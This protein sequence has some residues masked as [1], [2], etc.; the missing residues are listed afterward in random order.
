MP[1]DD[2][3]RAEESDRAADGH[4]GVSA[5]GRDCRQRGVRLGQCPAAK[6]M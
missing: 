5:H 6:A 4:S 3:V 2:S 1:L